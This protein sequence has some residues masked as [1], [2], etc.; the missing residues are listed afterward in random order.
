MRTIEVTDNVG[1]M[2]D[3]L[4]AKV[5]KGAGMEVSEDALIFMLIMMFTLTA[6]GGGG[7]EINKGR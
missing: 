7:V 5:E 4:R 2:L 1:K 3:T 6:L